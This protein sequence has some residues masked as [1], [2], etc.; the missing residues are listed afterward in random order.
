MTTMVVNIWMKTAISK[1]TRLGFSNYEARAYTA[2]LQDNPLTAYEIAKNSGIPTSKIYE[3]IRKLENRNTIQS[4]R[5]ERSP[6]Y[7]PL[8]PDEFV[9]NYRLSIENS[10]KSIRNSLRGVKVGIDTSYT[11][12]MNDYDDMILR[13]QR[14]L[15]TARQTALLMIWP[16]EVLRLMEDLTL[17]QERNIKIAVIHYGPTNIKVGQVYRHSVERSLY[18]EREL[19]GLTLVTDAQEAL[20]GTISGTNTDAIWSMNPAFVIMAEDYLRHD[21]YMMKAVTRF[22][23]VLK[24]TFGQRYEKLMDVFH[25][26]NRREC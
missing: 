9:E 2:L 3:V 6:L 4:I 21:I 20:T 24:K 5:S 19:R 8:P 14:M 11:W 7:I 13:A 23:P 1:L 17:A 12:H 15:G 25:D 22:D 26:E 10:L 18:A 16:D